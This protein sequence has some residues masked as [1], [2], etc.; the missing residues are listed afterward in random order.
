MVF[1]ASKCRLEIAQR[2]AEERD[3]ALDTSC[4]V[5]DSLVAGL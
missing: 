1:A 4:C 3:Y 5:I 2:W